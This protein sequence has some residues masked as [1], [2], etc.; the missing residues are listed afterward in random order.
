MKVVDVEKKETAISD[1]IV[2]AAPKIAPVLSIVAAAAYWGSTI[3]ESKSSDQQHSK[4]MIKHLD[5]SPK[6]E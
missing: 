2:K 6:V 1:S 3:N 5:S 4:K